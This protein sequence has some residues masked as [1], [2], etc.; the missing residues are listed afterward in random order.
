[1]S[2]D[3]SVI[4]DP[5]LSILGN[6]GGPTR[7][8]RPN[9]GSMLIDMGFNPSSD[10]TMLTTDQRTGLFVRSFDGDTS[11]SSED[12][13]PDI[14]AVE[15]QTGLFVAGELPFGKTRF[16]TTKTLMLSIA[17]G[18][19]STTVLEGSATAAMGA[20]EFDGA[21]G[22]FMISP[23]STV[24]LAYSFTPVTDDRTGKAGSVDI[25][26][27]TP[28]DGKTVV[29][30]GM[31]AGPIFDA[32]DGSGDP[33]DGMIDFGSVLIGQMNTLSLDLF[34][35][36][37]DGVG[38]FSDLTIL[39]IDPIG[40]N[41]GDFEVLGFT[42]GSP[43]VIPATLDGVTNKLALDI[44]FT[45]MGVG[46]RG[47]NI[48]IGTDQGVEKGGD[49]QIFQV[50]ASGEGIDPATGLLIHTPLLDFGNVR[51]G[52][53]SAPMDAEVQNN[54][55]P[56]SQLSGN[57]GGVNTDFGPG[58]DQP[59]GPLEQ[60][61]TDMRAY[62]FIPTGRGAAQAIADITSDNGT[63]QLIGQGVGPEFFTNAVPQ[64][65]NEFGFDFG[66]VDLGQSLSLSLEFGNGSDDPIGPLSNLTLLDLLAGGDTDEFDG[67]AALEMLEGTEAQANESDNFQITFTPS[68]EEQFLA[69]LMFLTDVGA[70]LGQ[71]GELYTILFKGDGRL[72]NPDPTGVPEPATTV[73]GL[74]GVGMIIR[75]R[76]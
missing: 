72:P 25:T 24:D 57:F 18:A 59:F 66:V 17:N 4:L 52:T 58:T 32:V 22:S 75:W 45:P 11:L 70:P 2:T 19:A 40:T 23:G 12:P 21:G 39:S 65:N 38:D 30:S 16:G 60:G 1:M 27:T 53:T 73:L 3:P 41:S 6:F 69:S 44:K 68:G 62:S 33:A 37:P 29:L 36:S 10:F 5:N 8:H 76:R 61:E 42:P 28:V 51:V 43:V 71:G 47:V 74:V 46:M 56:G 13:V 20:S 63:V 48:T 50:A 34:N 35:L 49:G 67:L 26:T 7:T 14:G 31:G 55:D 9:P 64:G 54:G 15:L